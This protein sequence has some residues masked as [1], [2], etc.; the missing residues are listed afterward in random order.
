M[1]LQFQ[2]LKISASI[3]ALYYLSFA[4]GSQLKR[5]LLSFSRPQI[6]R[7]FVSEAQQMA[8]GQV[9]R[10]VKWS[11]KLHHTTQW[12]LVGWGVIYSQCL[13]CITV[14][15]IIPSVNGYSHSSKQ[16]TFND[17]CVLEVYLQRQILN[18]EVTTIRNKH[19]SLNKSITGRS[20]MVFEK[21]FCLGIYYSL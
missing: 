14:I 4:N 2:Q 18:G 8:A 6:A 17:A 13:V 12:D 21:S 19:G 7:Q 20:H 10:S 3:K 9:K 5:L 15:N 11:D 16:F 1:W